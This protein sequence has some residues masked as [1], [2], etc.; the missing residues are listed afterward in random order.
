VLGQIIHTVVDVS[1]LEAFTSR[2]YCSWCS[3]L[4]PR[5]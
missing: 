2:I 5:Y 3:A 4:V 1:N